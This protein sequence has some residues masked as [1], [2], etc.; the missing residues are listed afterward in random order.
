MARYEYELW[1]RRERGWMP[2][3]VYESRKEAL[4]C[5]AQYMSYQHPYQCKIRRRTVGRWDPWEHITD[6]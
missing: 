1:C 2:D 4:E 6:E 5:A 3:T